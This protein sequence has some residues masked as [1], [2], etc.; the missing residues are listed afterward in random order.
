MICLLVLSAIFSL[1]SSNPIPPLSHSVPTL[2]Y[3]L[4]TISQPS[5]NPVLAYRNSKEPQVV[6]GF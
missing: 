5:L 6:V 4:P 3:L 1:P 2:S